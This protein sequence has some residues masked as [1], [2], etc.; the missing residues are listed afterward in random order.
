[1]CKGSAMASP[2]DSNAT[3]R[4][5]YLDVLRVIS[6]FAVCLI[7]T[8]LWYIENDAK[9]GIDYYD[10][11]R[12]MLWWCVPIFVMISGA[13]LLKRTVNLRQL[14]TKRILRLVVSLVFWSIVYAFAVTHGKGGFLNLLG[15]IA[16]GFGHA[17]FVYMIIGLYILLPILAKI[18]ESKKTMEYFLALS[19][20]FAFVIPRLIEIYVA[21]T[22]RNASII[23]DKINEMYMFLPLGYSGY[24]VLGYYLSNKVTNR[25]KE[26]IVIISALIVFAFVSF[27]YIF[28]AGDNILSQAFKMGYLTPTVLIESVAVFIVLKNH[29]KTKNVVFRKIFSEISDCAFGIYLIHILVMNFLLITVDITKY[30]GKSVF[31]MLIVNL[32][33]FLISLLLSM[34]IKRIPFLNKY[35]I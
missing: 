8:S 32:S 22:G 30:L 12:S 1:M 28:N 11:C 6:I 23:Q 17:W 24:F 26:I 34:G 7:H 16:D 35:I 21:F 9:A 18:T 31:S 4:I 14:Y 19:L 3:H 15:F 20:V 25:V 2:P 27:S 5:L 33:V 29:C 10:L 13:L